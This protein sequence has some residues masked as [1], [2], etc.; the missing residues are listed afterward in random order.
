MLERLEPAVPAFRSPKS[1]MAVHTGYARYFDLVRI[2]SSKTL[3]NRYRG[4]I[5]GVYWSLSNPILMTAIYSLIFGTT[6]SAYYDHSVV[7]YVVA[8]FTGL[9][10]L[11]IFANTTSQ[12]LTSVVDNGGLLNKIKLPVSVFPLSIV[13]SNTFQF[14]VGTL[15]VLALITIF[16]SRSPINV[17]ALIFPAIAL[18]LVTTGFSYIVSALYVFFRDLPYMYELVLFL[19]WITSPIFYPIE[20]VPERVRPYLAINPV[21]PIIDSLR[22]IALTPNLPDLKLIGW[23]LLTSVATLAIGL[24]TFHALR[25]DFMDL[26]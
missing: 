21:V 14:L 25:R 15:P 7:R 20:I 6:F 12:A 23:S 18:I 9:A 19:V 5:L 24:A 13:A 11:N 3:K 26:L 8:T 16:F 22:Q 17:I 2:L 10:I 1:T 4:S